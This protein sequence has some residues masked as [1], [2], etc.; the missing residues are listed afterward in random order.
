MERE[1]GAG[2]EA[3]QEDLA[4]APCR[5]RTVATRSDDLEAWIFLAWR[6]IVEDS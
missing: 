6:G 2:V 1:G 3:L 5:E 4:G